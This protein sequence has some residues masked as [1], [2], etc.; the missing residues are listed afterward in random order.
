MFEKSFDSEQMLD[1]IIEAI[2][3]IMVESIFGPIDFILGNA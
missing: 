2:G 3:M 1:S